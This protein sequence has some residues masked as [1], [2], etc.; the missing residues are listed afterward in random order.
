MN[1]IPL[2][3]IDATSMKE[4]ILY[5]DSETSFQLNG[6]LYMDQSEV[7]Q[8]TTGSNC[9]MYRF[10]DLEPNTKIWF[11]YRKAFVIDSTTVGFE[12]SNETKKV[13]GSMWSTKRF[14]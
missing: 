5:K 11:A 13:N 12:D 7:K 3:Y 9:T 1:T 8:M 4:I 10:Q 6:R 2:G 14:Y